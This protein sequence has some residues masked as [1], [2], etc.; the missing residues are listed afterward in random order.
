MHCRDG[1]LLTLPKKSPF[2]HPP[3]DGFATGSAP[4]VN[5]IVPYEKRVDNQD[6]FWYILVIFGAEMKTRRMNRIVTPTVSR[7]AS[8]LQER[9]ASGQYAENQWLPTER[10]LA[11][12]FV[13]SRATI[14]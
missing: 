4:G 13:V 3:A 1:S 11:D 10:E 12:E 14:R 9:I 8:T 5:R 2:C 7:I 6:T